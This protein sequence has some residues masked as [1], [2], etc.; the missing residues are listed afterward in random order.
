MIDTKIPEEYNP[1]SKV[2]KVRIEKGNSAKKEYLFDRSFTIG[3]SE[4][5]SIQ[6]DEGAVSRLHAEVIYENG[7]W[8]LMDKQSRNG[9]FFNGE[10]INRLEIKNT[11]SVELGRNGPVISFAFG[12]GEE[13]QVNRTTALPENG[14]VT[15]YI[16]HY[17]DESRS[18][19]EIGEHTR[20]MRK[21][22]D[23]V[24][25]KQ[26]SKYKKLII[27][28][29]A[30]A[31]AFAA[32]SVYQH[33]RENKQKLL[34]EN[35]FYNM[36]ALELEISVLKDKL[37]NSGDV[38][39]VG[40]L[41]KIDARHK[42]LEKNYDKLMDELGVYEMSEEDKLIIQTAR[43]F[44]ECELNVPG[45]FG[46]EVKRYIKKWQSSDRLGDAVQ[47]ANENNYTQLIVDNMVKHQMAPQFFYLA[48]QESNF[49]FQTV[50]PLTRFGYAKGIWQFIPQT[51]IKYGLVIGPL[52]SVKTYDPRDERY[53]FIKATAAAARYISDIYNT[54][55]QASGLLVAASYNWG[56][57]NIIDLIRKMPENPRDRNFWKLLEKYRD[58]IPDETYNYVFYI[59]SA[60]VIGE[61]PKLFGFNFRDPLKTPLE[62]LNN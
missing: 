9:T 2:I 36:K 29:A 8:W 51:A 23:I 55:A 15:D 16:Q 30:A 4:D 37:A 33:V 6:I 46:S 48:L 10:K 44:G 41:K 11:V 53:N 12:K 20:M 56:E 58:K 5:N 14:T 18:E 13:L 45:D 31:V 60:A 40:A 39:A 26:S 57:Y 24:K 35:I 59:F 3:R 27:I 61:N 52:A 28:T 1:D 42:Q 7:R 22:F 43:I 19:N 21:A 34:A 50:G 49:D 47:R 17:F 62:K 32:Y 54:D 25:K 38:S